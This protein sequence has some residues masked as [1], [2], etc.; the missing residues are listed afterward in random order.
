MR[1]LNEI[2]TAVRDGERP[3][4]DELRYAICAMD[5]LGVFNRNALMKLAEAEKAQKKPFLTTSAE[6]QWQEHYRREKAAGEKSPKEYIGWNND[7][8]NPEFLRRRETAKR[9]MQSISAAASKS[10]ARDGRQI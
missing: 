1:T 9:L 4:Y 6:W 10:P 2:V 3:D 7:P 5:A 8:E